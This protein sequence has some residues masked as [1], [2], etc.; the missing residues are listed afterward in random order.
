MDSRVNWMDRLF[1]RFSPAEI[2]VMGF[3]LLI[4]L[5]AVLLTLPVAH[6]S[7]E[8]FPFLDA[9]FTATSAVCVTGLVVA[10]TAT[11]FSRFG[12][13]VIIMLIQMG[14]L[15][16]MTIS[17]LIFLMLGKRIG[18]R[19]RLA[20]QEQLGAHG[21]SGV[22]R[23]AKSVVFTSLL[24]EGVGA[25]LL[26]LRFLAYRPTGEA[27]WWGIFHAIS[28]FNNAGFDITFANM[29][30]LH[31][32]AFVLL[33]ISMLIFLGGIGF[34]VL[35]EMWRNRLRWER[36]TVHARIALSVSLWAIG[37]GALLYLIFEWTNPLTFGP[38]SPP[39]KLLNALFASV[40][41]RTAGFE[42]VATGAFRPVTLLLT[43]LLM[44]MGASPG[45]TGGGVKTTTVTMV[46]LTVRRIAKGEQ[47]VQLFGRRFSQAITEKALAVTVLAAIL[48]VLWTALLLLTERQNPA[49]SLEWVLFEVVSAFGTTG[50]TAG[51]TPTLTAPG[52]LLIAA[53]MFIGR[54]GPLTLAVA[55]AGRT[56][57]RAPLSY[58]E[59]RV[60]IG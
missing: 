42:S 49:A 47:E 4:L 17:G 33:P 6:N 26:T 14:G 18:L 9:L 59:E 7:G 51:L 53:M 27:I 38:M 25:L 12:Q 15:G 28:A 19:E 5:G 23:L 60:M 24:I 8:P 40:T 13:G 57:Q 10:D 52:K 39:V 30:P 56:K 11:E 36:L 3:A 55:L 22:V 46:A 1:H 54:L 37:L 32:D 20:M 44:F 16:I 41:P 29:K 45:G 50:L 58:P 43:I 31:G 21:M 48:V 34:P 2:L 35:M